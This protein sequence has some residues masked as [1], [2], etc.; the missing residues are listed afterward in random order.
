MSSS[1]TQKKDQQKGNAPAPVDAD[2]KLSMFQ[3]ELLKKIRNK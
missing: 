1:T 2:S 3:K